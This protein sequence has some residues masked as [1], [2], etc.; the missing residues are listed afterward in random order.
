VIQEWWPDSKEVTDV[1]SA[2]PQALRPQPIAI[3]E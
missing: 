2:E 1:D 3:P